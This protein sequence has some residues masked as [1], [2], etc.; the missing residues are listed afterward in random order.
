MR[1]RENNNPTCLSFL[2]II[3]AR[4]FQ[5]YSRHVEHNSSLQCFTMLFLVRLLYRAPGQAVF[6][7]RCGA[8]DNLKF[9]TVTNEQNRDRSQ[10]IIVRQRTINMQIHNFRKLK[11]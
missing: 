8:K 3:S 2:L 5:H 9:K 7:T 6:R 4:I 10:K 11:F 1:K